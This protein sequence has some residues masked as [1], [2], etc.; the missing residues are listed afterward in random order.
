MNKQ[1]KQIVLC[2][3][4]AHSTPSGIVQDIRGRGSPAKQVV[5]VF[6]FCLFS[7]D[8]MQVFN[9]KIHSFRIIS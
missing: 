1:L 2:F 7:V 9:G 3:K 4:A 5:G 6:V 8:D